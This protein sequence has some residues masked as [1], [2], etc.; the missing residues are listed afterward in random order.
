MALL[1]ADEEVLGRAATWERLNGTAPWI[2][3]DVR[4][5]P[6]QMVRLMIDGWAVAVGKHLGRNTYRLTERGR[7][8]AR[9]SVNSG[10]E[11][12]PSGHDNRV[13]AG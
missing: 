7:Q 6:S 4:A 3:S 10:G 13:A 5:A 9:G 1:K 11:S 12:G 8:A 2:W